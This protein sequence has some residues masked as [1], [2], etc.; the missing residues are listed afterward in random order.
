MAH[1]EAEQTNA[2]ESY[3][4]NELTEEQRSRFEEHYFECS[5]CADALIAGQAFLEGV[6][7]LDPWWKRWV[8]LLQ[9]PVTVPSWGIWLLGGA[10]AASLALIT[11]GNFSAV[12]AA[13]ANTTILAKQLEKGPTDDNAY[14][15]STPSATVEVMPPDDAPVFPFYR[16]TIARDNR[17]L[18]S[19][20]LPVE[21]RQSGRRL[22]MQVSTKALGV[23]KFTVFL[24][25]LATPKAK[26]SLDLQ[27]YFFEVSDS[28]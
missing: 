8:A 24:K 23:G 3:L 19:R 4:L 21:S 15:L 11:S 6:R 12:P 5:I 18:A 27:S 16:M 14:K 26:N 20:V 7:S 17:E 22:S 25:G 13:M 10:A 2:V 9:K 28:N 1:E